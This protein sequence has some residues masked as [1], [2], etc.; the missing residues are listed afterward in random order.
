MIAGL[1][2][3]VTKAL[4]RKLCVQLELSHSEGSGHAS[5][6]IF[7]AHG[8][9]QSILNDY[10]VH[11]STS[12]SRRLPWGTITLM[13]LVLLPVSTPQKEPSSQRRSGKIHEATPLIPRKFK[14]RAIIW[15]PLR[16]ETVCS[17][18]AWCGCSPGAN[19]DRLALIRLMQLSPPLGPPVSRR[20]H[21]LEKL[22]EISE[23][24]QILMQKV[25]SVAVYGYTSDIQAD[26]MSEGRK[27]PLSM[28]LR[29]YTLRYTES[30]GGPSRLVQPI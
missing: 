2:Y 30:P 13:T 3:T 29:E 11:P 27:G 18:R 24:R 9:I 21:S 22:A 28:N 8:R 16:G 15:K 20:I 26:R 17:P 23:F 12:T 1:D 5:V 19:A 14:Y 6:L 25:L 4:T 10:F 7:S